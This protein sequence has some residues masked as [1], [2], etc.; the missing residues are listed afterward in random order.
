MLEHSRRLA[1]EYRFY[2][3]IYT[4]IC[5]DVLTVQTGNGIGGFCPV[6]LSDTEKP[7]LEF[8]FVCADNAES[9]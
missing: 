9:G 7:I 8:Q 4:V 5:Y 2:T 1:V 6:F 3:V